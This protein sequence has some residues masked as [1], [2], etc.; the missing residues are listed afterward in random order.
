MVPGALFSLREAVYEGEVNCGALS[1]T[2]DTVTCT[3]AVPC[4]ETTTT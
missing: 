3:V 2:S 4:G 1:F